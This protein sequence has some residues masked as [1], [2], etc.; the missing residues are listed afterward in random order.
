M[1]LSRVIDYVFVGGVLLLVAGVGVAHLMRG[2][3]NPGSPSAPPASMLATVPA[4]AVPGQPR[5]PVSRT[6]QP[7]PDPGLKD[8]DF[9]GELATIDRLVEQRQLTEALAA[10]DRLVGCYENR[11]KDYPTEAGLAFLRRGEVFEAME[12]FPEGLV[13]FERTYF[14][15]RDDTP[16]VGRAWVRAYD[17]LTAAYLRA[18]RFSETLATVDRALYAARH[19]PQSAPGYELWFH[20]RKVDALLALGRRAEACAA[21]DEWRL[22]LPEKYPDNPATRSDWYRQLAS[23]YRQLNRLDLQLDVLRQAEKECATGGE[24]ETATDF[25]R[26]LAIASVLES[27]GRKE[28]AA[29]LALRLCERARALGDRPE[30][31]RR[32]AELFSVLNC[33]GRCG[34]ALAIA[35]EIAQAHQEIG[36]TSPRTRREDLARVAASLQP[37]GHFEEAARTRGEVAELSLAAFGADSPEHIRDLYSLGFIF[38]H[39]DRAAAA[40]R[41]MRECVARAERLSPADDVLLEDCLG[42]LGY[43]LTQSST[44]DYHGAEPFLRRALELNQ[45]RRGPL[46]SSAADVRSNLANT[47]LHLGR[48]DDAQRVIEENITSLRTANT[49]LSDEAGW[50]HHLAARIHVAKDQW[51]EAYDD[52]GRSVEIRERLLGPNDYRTLNMLRLHVQTSWRAGHR[53]ESVRRAEQLLEFARAAQGW[54]VFRDLVLCAELATHHAEL[55]DQSRAA[56]LGRLIETAANRYYSP[57]MGWSEPRPPADL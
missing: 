26:R 52:S 19:T 43:F 46:H 15:W 7:S 49:H 18:G 40:V 55:G 34:Q 12:R 10:A 13:E 36:D 3:E 4:E 17:R 38:H 2:P 9:L 21:A 5:A 28:Q 14:L 41:I 29:E 54:P 8:S 37:L 35:R 27:M 20:A 11:A 30:K 44:P 24:S 25:A 51:Q 50:A 1:S 31:L 48:H 57:A 53:E 22:R 47:L 23:V 56:E 32:L 39:A 33:T 16:D 42:V 45:R 6:P